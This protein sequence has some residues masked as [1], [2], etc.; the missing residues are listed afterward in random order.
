M[1]GPASYLRGGFS[2]TPGKVVFLALRHASTDLVRTWL[3]HRALQKAARLDF[4]GRA[5]RERTSMA[6][7]SQVF[8]GTISRDVYG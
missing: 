8:Q 6:S 7:P 4:L 5:T 1:P 2:S 3:R